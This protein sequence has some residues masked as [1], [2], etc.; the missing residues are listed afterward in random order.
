MVKAIYLSVFIEETTNSLNFSESLY[1]SIMDNMGGSNFENE[2]ENGPFLNTLGS[3]GVE[4]G[5]LHEGYTGSI[6]QDFFYDMN[7]YTIPAIACMLIHRGHTMGGIP[8]SKLPKHILLLEMLKTF[9]PV[10][11]R[12]KFIVDA[13]E[14]FLDIATKGETKLTKNKVLDEFAE[15]LMHFTNAGKTGHFLSYGGL[16]LY[17]ISL[18]GEGGHVRGSVKEFEQIKTSQEVRDLGDFSL[19]QTS[20]SNH[21]DTSGSGQSRESQLSGTCT[22]IS[23]ISADPM[24]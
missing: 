21:S 7:W 9:G 16:I 4:L 14:I 10:G 19:P 12:K 17:A 24:A 1:N 2:F 13:V 23:Q 20:L 22:A 5:K 8:L 6:D 15:N 11:G 18:T 3:L